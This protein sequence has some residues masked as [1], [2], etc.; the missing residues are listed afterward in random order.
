L[1][2][3]IVKYVLLDILRSKVAVAY[4]AALALAAVGLFH[5]GDSGKGLVSLLS[6][7]LLVV[8][9]V[10]LVFA[11]THFYNSY[12]F[13]ELLAAQPLHRRTIV[14]AE[15]FGVAGALS[16]AFLLGAGL[17]VALFDGTATG[18]CLIA[19]G[20]LLTLVFV[21]V[22]FL[23]AVCTRDKA[24]G[25]GVALLMWFYFSLVYDGLVLLLLYAFADYPLEKAAMAMMA[26]NPVDLGRVIVLLHMDV[27][28]LMGYTGAV[29]R[30]FLGSW[31][32]MA[33]AFGLLL[34]WAAAPLWLAVRVFRSKDL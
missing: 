16:V 30:Q 6:V 4:T 33:S 18:L 23:G 15:Y 21:A 22:A 19:V 3:R 2:F 27:S 25:I 5:L 8:P 26:L 34:A 12:E 20:V 9:L 17:P 13:I 29:L 14:L 31:P 32:G 11:T 28:V 24:R 10:G 7:V 1:V